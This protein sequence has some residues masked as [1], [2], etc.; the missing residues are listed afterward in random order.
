MFGGGDD[1]E[2]GG[3]GGGLMTMLGLAAG[4]FAPAM[5]YFGFGNV[6]GL[7]GGAGAAPGATG[8]AGPAAAPAATTQ[9]PAVAG[10]PAPAAIGQQPAASAK[11]A[12]P[13]AVSVAP[14]SMQDIRQTAKQDPNKAVGMVADMAKSDPKVMDSF[15]ELDSNLKGVLS[16][17][18]T[19]A[20]VAKR[21]N[22][23]LTVQDADMLIKNW[24][25]IRSAIGM[26]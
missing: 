11:P 10:Q 23:L 26:K 17:F 12:A 18:V 20:A 22:G 8:P 1:D 19:P 4:L 14:P 3:G 13:A 24:P 5:Q 6:L 2:E 15:K 21:S 16:R 9:Q 7:P 25:A